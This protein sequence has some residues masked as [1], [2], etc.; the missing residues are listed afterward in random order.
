[1]VATDGAGNF[2]EQAVTL[3][4]NNRDEVAPVITSSGT[5]PAINENSGA[6]QVVYTVTSTD[7]DVVSGSTTYSLKSGVGDVADFTINGS[8]GAVTLIGNPNF[9]AKPSYAFTVV[10]TDAAGNFDEQPVTLAINDLDETPPAVSHIGLTGA[11]GGQNSL[12]NAGDIVSATVTMTENTLVNTSGGTPTIELTIGGDRVDAVYAS[13]SGTPN[14]IFQYTIQPGENDNSGISFRANTLASHGASIAD[15]VGNVANLGHGGVISNSAF[16]VDTTAPTLSSS[17]PPDNATDVPTGGDLVLTFNENVQAG[18]GNIVISSTFDTR[19]FNITDPQITVS[20][21]QVTINP[22][23]DLNLGTDY[24]VQVDAGAITD[25]AGNA[26]AG[27]S[28][29]TTLNFETSFPVLPL[30]FAPD[31]GADSGRA[32]L[33]GGE[34]IDI[35]PAVAMDNAASAWMGSADLGSED[36][37]A[38]AAKGSDAADSVPTPEVAATNA[39]IAWQT[40]P[41][42]VGLWADS[43]PLDPSTPGAAA[44]GGNHADFIVFANVPGLTSQGLA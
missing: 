42:N 39:A 30:M 2:H 22:T 31:P 41:G 19:T 5:A 44:S 17:T 33:L 43:T 26:Y 14:L 38:L 12:L 10:A 4:I 11:I 18:S 36:R 25:R 16:M 15:A 29:T 8:T 34:N 40:S 24:S 9:E 3:A 6:N 7:T 28:N 21:N 20:G 1:M 32:F 23:T 27:I 13:G 35:V 37:V